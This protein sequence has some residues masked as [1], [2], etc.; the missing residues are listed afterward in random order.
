MW[1]ILL[2]KLTPKSFRAMV[3]RIAAQEA[4]KMCEMMATGGY[5]QSETKTDVLVFGLIK[6]V[7]KK[8]MRKG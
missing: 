2:S 8:D 5:I 1:L 6:T 7:P 3:D 4:D